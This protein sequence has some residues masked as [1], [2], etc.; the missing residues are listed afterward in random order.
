MINLI[1]YEE[2]IIE[3]ETSN[4]DVPKFVIKPYP[5]D[6]GFELVRERYKRFIWVA[7]GLGNGGKI[8]QGENP[9][10][11]EAAFDTSIDRDS[12][13][14]A[15]I[16]GMGRAADFPG[17][18]T[19]GYTKNTGTNYLPSEYYE[20]PDKKKARKLKKI[21]DFE[22]FIVSDKEEEK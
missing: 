9:P 21:K 22:D 5:G 11:T 20:D 14:P 15:E 1:I 8:D 13:N 7:P 2:F 6:K 12:F 10:V 16:S 18:H 4:Y 19:P 17:G 3:N